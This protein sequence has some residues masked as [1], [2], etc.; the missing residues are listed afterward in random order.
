MNKTDF[1]GR[2][3]ELAI[4]DKL[5]ESPD[6]KLLILY[7]RRRIGKTRLL[8]H[9]L[10]QRPKRAI[11]WVAEPSSA[12]HQLRSFSQTIY[13]FNHPDAPA[14]RDFAYGNWEQAFGEVARLAKDE[15]LALFIDEVTYLIEVDVSIV[16]TLQKVWDHSLKNTH[17]KLALSGS[18]RG[19]MEEEIISHK[20]P[21]YGRAAAHIELP[22]L[23]FGAINKFFPEYGWG[24][25]VHI[26]SVFGGVPAYWERLDV[27]A[28]VIENIRTQLLTSNTLMQEEPRLLLQDFISDTH[29][30][31]GILQG[32]AQGVHTQIGLS[33]Y[34]GLSQGH[35]SKYLSVLRNTGFVE[36][37]VPVTEISRRS[38][39]GRYFITDPYLRFYYRFLSTLQTELALG[40]PS[41]SLNQIEEN[42][43]SF[44]EKNTWSELCREWLVGASQSGEFETPL[45]SVG[46][47]WHKGS[48][49]IDVVGL[50]QAERRLVL[51]VC[52]WQ[53]QPV[54]GT[55]LRD[56]LEQTSSFVPKK[57]KWIV[58]YLGFSAS[59]WTIEAET[60]A[61]D[62]QVSGAA[63]SN[64]QSESFK[65]FNLEDICA[66]L[67]RWMPSTGQ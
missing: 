8:V 47:A 42:F 64:W 15:R 21:L 28:S 44:I 37:Q 22:P 12:L 58:D 5:W 36:R 45:E 62:V 55:T 50:N 43:P 51:G 16:G 31:V 63:K 20:A 38:R 39:R 49:D 10:E 6:A 11:Y 9:W 32:I 60:L 54:G 4:L 18:Q 25:L 41:E 52:R 3:N 46:A 1:V 48:S 17:I 61:Q 30:Y 23:P 59:G 13:N 53:E 57:G 24:D 2:I 65:L 33:R 40:N 67:A 34:S 14:P 27:D 56:L 7:G 35:I 29:N 19:L 26:Y 66:D